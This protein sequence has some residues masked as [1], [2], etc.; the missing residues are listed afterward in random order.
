MATVKD[1]AK[2]ANV[3]TSAISRVL[4]GDSSLSVTEETRNRINTIAQELKYE[5]VRKSRIAA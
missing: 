4:N 3:S 2:N 1:I 5:P